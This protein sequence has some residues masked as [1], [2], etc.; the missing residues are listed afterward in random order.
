MGDPWELERVT[1][2]AESI[3]PLLTDY[4]MTSDHRFRAPDGLRKVA[5]SEAYGI[6]RGYYIIDDT[7][8]T[9]RM[10]CKLKMPDEPGRF[11]PTGF[12]DDDTIIFYEDLAVP[13]FLVFKRRFPEWWW[14]HLQRPEVW[15]AIAIALVWLVRLMRTL[16]AALAANGTI[17]HPE[18]P[19]EPQK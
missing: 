14:G 8:G 16:V 3:A 15:G 5:F 10:L 4:Y 1:E 7:D 13:K 2:D 9:N 12:T 18:E 17:K 6:Y 11:E 19:R